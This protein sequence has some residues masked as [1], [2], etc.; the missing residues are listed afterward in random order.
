MKYLVVARDRELF[1][2]W[3]SIHGHTMG[4][5]AFYVTSTEQMRGFDARQTICVLLPGY[6]NQGVVG[7]NTYQ[8]MVNR[9]MQT[10]NCTREFE[11]SYRRVTGLKAEEM[12]DLKIGDIV[13]HVSRGDNYVVTGNYGGRVTAVRSVDITNCIEWE[14]VNKPNKVEPNYIADLPP[15]MKEHFRAIHDR[16]QEKVAG[17]MNVVAST[18]ANGFNTRISLD[19]PEFTYG[20]DMGN[21]KVKINISFERD[22]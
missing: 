17:L 22:R 1:R 19:A 20:W 11:D 8:H 13:K 2:R 4:I 6:Q 7:T 10:M 5:D 3:C 16:I 15:E 18:R 14:L 21:N 12:R 9:G